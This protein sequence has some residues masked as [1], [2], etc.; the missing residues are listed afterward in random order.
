MK[1]WKRKGE[2]MKVVTISQ[3]KFLPGQKHF[4]QRKKKSKRWLP[5]PTSKYLEFFVF[6]PEKEPSGYA[7]GIHMWQWWF[8]FFFLENKA[9]TFWCAVCSWRPM[10]SQQ[11]CNCTRQ[12]DSVFKLTLYSLV[13]KKKGGGVIC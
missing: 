12:C 11:K 9:L 5:P 6:L 4:M 2:S 3:W 1:N 7:P 10:I 8:F 13:Q